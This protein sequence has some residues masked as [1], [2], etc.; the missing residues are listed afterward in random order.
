MS[1][2]EKVLYSP[3]RKYV[4]DRDFNVL[5]KVPKNME[6]FFPWPLCIGLIEKCPYLERL[7]K[8]SRRPALHYTPARDG[9]RPP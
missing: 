2:F 8:A 1:K 7:Q 9:S 6:K 3:C 4:F 5:R